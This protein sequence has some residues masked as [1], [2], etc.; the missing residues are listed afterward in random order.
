MLPRLL[1][2]LALLPVLSSADYYT[3]DALTVS[4]QPVTA[5]GAVWLNLTYED[6]GYGVISIPGARQVW[7]YARLNTG[8]TRHASFRLEKP[9]AT[10]QVYG[11][12][13][14][15]SAVLTT[16]EPVREPIPTVEPAIHVDPKMDL[17]I[18]S[19][20][21][22]NSIEGLPQ[23]LDTV[24]NL[25]PLSKALGFNGI[26]SYVKWNFVERKPGE[27]D[28]SFYDALL[29]EMDKNGLRWFP[30]LIVGSAYS[31]PEWFFNS[32]EMVGY[33][34]LEHN[35]RIEIP[36][37][38]NHN[39]DKYVRRFLLEFGK[40]Y[41]NRKTLLGVR[42]GP[43]GNYG[44]AQYPATGA[45]G[46]R[47]RGLH[48]HLGYW[49]GDAGASVVFRTWLRERYPSIAALNTAWVTEYRSFDDV[50]TFL[51]QTAH[52]S[53]MR[54]DF[55]NWYMEAMSDW[56]DQWAKWAREAMPRTSIYQSS[57][58]WGAVEIGTDY[59]AHAKSMA[60]LH[61]G[62]RL[63]NENDSYLNNVG[64][65]RLAMSA[66][67]FYGAK[68]GSEPA[69]FSSVR[70]V[71]GRLYNAITNNA[72]HL[73]YYHGNLFDNDQAVEAWIRQA[74]LLNQRAK[75]AAEIAVFYP[76]TDN[77][78]ND[79]VLSKLKASAFFQRIQPLRSV[80]DYDFAS[81]QMILDGA[82]DRYKVL[83]VAW[84][85]TTEKPVLE[86]IARWVEAGGVLIYPERQHAR[87]G[88]FFTVEG[89]KTIWTAWQ[90]GD[91]G[92]GRVIF[93]RG[94]PE[95][96]HYYI[97]FLRDEL[98]KLEALSGATRAALAMDKPEESY[99]CLLEGGKL[100]LMN[101]DD[102]PSTIRLADG[103]TLQ[104]APYTIQIV[105]S[106]R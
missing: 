14:V 35:E 39:Q 62:I 7:G 8:G 80:T 19:G 53:R 88:G 86:R 61:G 41:A 48:T 9:A 16:K 6:I 74:P 18:S 103:R 28:W 97:S 22:A 76:D 13:A 42:L 64:A 98:R 24:R 33:E 51:P 69:G 65:T 78:L 10:V 67:R 100:A 1:L 60:A 73:F 27:F 31:L 58:G 63:T 68:I 66:A 101:Y 70:G 93:F 29:D 3:R 4:L 38:F 37:I 50:K 91:T 12:P 2:T 55:S 95:P 106:R 94:H 83:I 34:C 11:L 17:V 81:E 45:M 92:K 102:E 77:R 43:S 20:A 79:E 44:E 32:P 52:T 21:D 47:N 30:L 40:H 15:V 5:A 99:W 82:L 54:L 104:I 87:D 36:T 90:K 25:L 57:G 96:V 46:Y 23:S 75:P 71:E 49:A 84:A 85:H 105:E 26:E 59:T 89:D 72:G 56:C